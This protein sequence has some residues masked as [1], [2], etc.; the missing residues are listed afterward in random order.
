MR[1]IS[2]FLAGLILTSALAQAAKTTSIDTYLWDIE[3]YLLLYSATGDERFLV[4][5]DELD[6]AF[7]QRLE[8]QRNANALK[9]M[10]LLYLQELKQVREAYFNSREDLEGS[11]AKLLEVIELF[12]NFIIE[13]R[14]T[15]ETS[16]LT[17]DLRE[18][19]LQEARQANSKLLNIAQDNGARITQLQNKI[20]IQIETLD[21]RNISL[22]WDFIRKSQRPEGN[23]LLFIFNAQIEYLINYL[24]K[25][26]LG[27]INEQI[28]HPLKTKG[29]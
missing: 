15:E 1:L 24:G 11:V 5:L 4:R 21:D 9:D 25:A 3:R 6:T 20:E 18:I 13:G 12:D 23:T 28:I 29:Y 16:T 10:R 14:L 2:I 27:K 7:K 8:A 26:E 22:R 17:D 19:A